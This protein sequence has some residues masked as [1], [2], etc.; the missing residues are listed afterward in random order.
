[1]FLKMKAFFLFILDN[2][3][4]NYDVEHRIVGRNRKLSSGKYFLFYYFGVNC[5]LT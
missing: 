2:D 4:D 5:C 1:M 3:D